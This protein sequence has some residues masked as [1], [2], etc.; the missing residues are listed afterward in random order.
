MSKELTKLK[1]KAYQKSYYEKNKVAQCQK[2]RD[3]YYENREAIRAKIKKSS[4]I[5]YRSTRKLLFETFGSKC[6]VCGFDDIRA[7]HIDHINGGG[8]QHR[9]SFGGN[10]VGYYRDMMKTPDKYQTLCAN[11][12]TIKMYERKEHPSEW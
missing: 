7:L 9:L 4:K 12:N 11:C 6:S 2:A 1:K 3:Y 10:Y 5:R 8:R